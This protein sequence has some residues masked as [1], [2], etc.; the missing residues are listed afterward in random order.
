MNAAYAAIYLYGYGI[1]IAEIIYKNGDAT[2]Y[3]K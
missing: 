2:G 3:L 1:Q